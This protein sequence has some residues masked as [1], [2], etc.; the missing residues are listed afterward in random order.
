[1]E[2]EIVCNRERDLADERMTITNIKISSSNKISCY[3]RLFIHPVPI[4]HNG[5]NQGYGN[6]IWMKKKKIE[7]LFKKHVFP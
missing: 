6:R 3:L 2:E 5:S 4:R 1:M 7:I